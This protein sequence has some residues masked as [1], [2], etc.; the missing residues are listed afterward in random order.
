MPKMK[1]CKAIAKRV[2]ITACGKVKTHKIGRRHLATSKSAKTKRN[3]RRTWLVTGPDEKKIK[4]ALP[5][6]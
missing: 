5:Y 2:K 3:L 6:A 1:T 4:M